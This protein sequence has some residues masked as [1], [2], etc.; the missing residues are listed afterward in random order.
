MAGLRDH[1]RVFCVVAEHGSFTRAAAKLHMTQSAVSQQMKNLEE[2]LGAVLFDRRNRRQVRLTESG[3]VVQSYA[4]RILQLADEMHRRVEE[5]RQVVRGTLTIGASYTVGEYILPM[6]LAEFNDL[7]P[8]IEYQ[9]EIDN[10]PAV[11]QGLVDHRLDVGLVESAVPHRSVLRVEGLAEDEMR[12]IVPPRHRLATAVSTT[13]TDLQGETWIVREKG[14]GTR[15]FTDQVLRACGVR[16][17]RII[18]F[19][20]THGIKEAVRAGL[21]IA[22]LSSWALQPEGALDT[23]PVLR[24][25]GLDL[26]RPLSLVIPPPATASKAANVFAGF[27]RSRFTRSAVSP[28]PPPC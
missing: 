15:E 16:A 23:L 6:V 18:A 14:S 8:E 24:I 25:S 10:T 5:V 20:S 1:L 4:R 28:S 11:V 7:Y 21:G 9:V 27:V 22:L 12:L 26:R 2:E 3:Q 13:P 17:K 19:S